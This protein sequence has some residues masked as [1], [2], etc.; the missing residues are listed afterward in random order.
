MTLPDDSQTPDSQ[1]P[2]VP[3]PR[4]SPRRSGR[5]LLIGG[6]TALLLVGAWAG[7]TVYS[8]GQAETVSTRLSGTIDAALKSNNLGKVERHTFARGLTS[9][10]DDI[11]LVLGDASGPTNGPMRLH[12]R[13]RI[14]H[15]PLLGFSA[16]G[17]AVVDTEI[18]WDSG[19]T[20]GCRP[21][22][23]GRSAARNPSCTR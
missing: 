9:S 8:A 23:T 17:Q 16:M 6:V 5:G 1:T 12:L 22:W 13:N 19:T 14:Q 2:R 21:P 18:I 3:A 7:S 11:Y 4:P 15:G 20:P 10:T